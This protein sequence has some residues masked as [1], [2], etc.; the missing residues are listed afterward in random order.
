MNTPSGANSW[1]QV[2]HHGV[3]STKS[4]NPAPNNLIM[5]FVITKMITILLLMNS[6][7]EKLQRLDALSNN[8]RLNVKFARRSCI[9]KMTIAARKKVAE[10][11]S[12]ALA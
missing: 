4:Q 7:Q 10:Q 6:K 12:A 9:I 8:A 3:P 1:V 11:E 5:R 2:V